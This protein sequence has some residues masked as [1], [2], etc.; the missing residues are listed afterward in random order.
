MILSPDIY[1]GNKM[2]P[3]IE[4]ISL[5]CKLYKTV[6]ETADSHLLLIAPCLPVVMF[7]GTSS[8]GQSGKLRVGNQ[9]LALK[10]VQGI[11]QLHFITHRNEYWKSNSHCFSFSTSSKFDLCTV[12]K[13]W[14]QNH[15]FRDAV[16][17]LFVLLKHQ[18]LTGLLAKTKMNN[19]LIC[20]MNCEW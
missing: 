7:P 6:I 4:W 2:D 15:R 18:I 19:V 3:L 10:Y 8:S 12:G 13:F 1:V 16:N 5:S 17:V 9:W 20:R 14:K 11:V